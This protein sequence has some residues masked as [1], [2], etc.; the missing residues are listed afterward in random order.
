VVYRVVAFFSGRTRQQSCLRC[1]CLSSREDFLLLAPDEKTGQG[2]IA[3]LDCLACGEAHRA[4]SA[5]AALH[6][7]LIGQ[8]DY[9]LLA[10]PLVVRRG[11]AGAPEPGSDTVRVRRK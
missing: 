11:P 2:P 3:E 9:E 1:L 7:E 6:G 10:A 4:V 5:E 8:A